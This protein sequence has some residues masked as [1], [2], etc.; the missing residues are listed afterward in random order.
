MKF[1]NFVIYKLSQ[2]NLL[3][4]INMYTVLYKIILLFNND[5]KVYSVSRTIQS[6]QPNTM[7]ILADLENVENGRYI[8]FGFANFITNQIRGVGLDISLNEI[9]TDAVSIRREQF[10]TYKTDSI[11][12][13]QI[14]CHITTF[15]EIKSTDTVYLS[16]KQIS[17]ISSICYSTL[18]VIK[19]M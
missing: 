15:L 16:C 7:T 4:I 8:I 10:E 1:L 19:Y 6:V 3:S 14:D 11:G 17:E 5:K 18:T 12:F 2:T 13:S 9:P